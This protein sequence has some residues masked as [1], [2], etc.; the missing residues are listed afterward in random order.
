[1][2]KLPGVAG[3]GAAGAAQVLR[4]YGTLENAFKAGRFPAQAKDLRLFRS[5]ATMDRKA[6]LPRLSGQRP[7]WRKAAARARAWELNQLAKRL[8]D[9][10][11]PSNSA[12][13]SKGVP[14]QPIP[15]TNRAP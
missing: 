13:P 7:T 1:A 14:A 5:I 6:P 15:S 12:K 10:A 8:D 3:L 4:T 11:A 9:L 2:D